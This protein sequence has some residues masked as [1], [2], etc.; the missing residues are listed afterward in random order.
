MYPK[1]NKTVSGKC[2]Q[3]W[4]KCVYVCLSKLKTGRLIQE[5]RWGIWSLPAPLLEGPWGAW[6]GNPLPRWHALKLALGVMVTDFV[7]MRMQVKYPSGEWA[8]GRKC[9]CPCKG[10]LSSLGFQGRNAHLVCSRK[11]DTFFKPKISS[12]IKYRSRCA[13]VKYKSVAALPRVAWGLPAKD[14]SPC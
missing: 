7:G 5:P 4:E 13:H 14:F 3:D 6:V 10:T 9:P 8:G 2:I 1:T 11:S 12:P